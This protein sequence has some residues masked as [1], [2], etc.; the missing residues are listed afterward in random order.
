MPRSHST[1]NGTLSMFGPMDI[2]MTFWPEQVQFSAY[3]KQGVTVQNIGKS[4]RFFRFCRQICVFNRI[5][6]TLETTNPWIV[7][8]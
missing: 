4:G 3:G 2:P 7:K 5:K 6:V 1:F 8:I